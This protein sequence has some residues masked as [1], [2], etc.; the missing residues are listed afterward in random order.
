MKSPTRVIANNIVHVHMYV[1]I[2]GIAASAAAVTVVK[3]KR[4]L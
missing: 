1:R 3:K 4:Y 2:M